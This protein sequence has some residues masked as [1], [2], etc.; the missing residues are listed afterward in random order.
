MSIEINQSEL[1]I[2]NYPEI[3]KSP[4]VL[5][6]QST[7]GLRKS[8]L[9]LRKS[10]LGLLIKS[11]L[12]QLKLLL[13]LLLLLLLCVCVCEHM[14]MC[15]CFYACMCVCAGVA[16]CGCAR[17]YIHVLSLR[18]TRITYLYGTN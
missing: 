9:G 15:M 6:A 12:G 5:F 10:T 1:S 16:V 7:L 11:T 4:N 3:S 17:V 13:L 14:C 2:S 8:T 18:Y